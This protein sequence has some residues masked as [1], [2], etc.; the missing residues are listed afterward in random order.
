MLAAPAQVEELVNNMADANNFR[1]SQL[2][3]QKTG[4]KAARRSRCWSNQAG[5]VGP[6]KLEVVRLR[7]VGLD[8]AQNDSENVAAQLPLFLQVVIRKGEAEESVAGER[9][10][11]RQSESGCGKHM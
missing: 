5:A 3:W 10:R 4:R 7:H 8:E 9:K 1:L 6:H 11:D 2:T